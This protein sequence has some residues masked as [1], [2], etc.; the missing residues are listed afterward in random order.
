[1][2][3]DKQMGLPV[4]ILVSE[5]DFRLETNYFLMPVTVLISLIGI[6]FVIDNSNL[7]INVIYAINADNLLLSE[8]K[9]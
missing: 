8:D 7:G 1:M 6:R 4:E 9:V 2:S 5:K 3:K